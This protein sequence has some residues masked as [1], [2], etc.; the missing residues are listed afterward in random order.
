MKVDKVARHI[1]SNHEKAKECTVS[2]E[3]WRLKTNGVRALQFD[4]FFTSIPQAEELSRNLPERDRMLRGTE[5][6]DYDP[7]KHDL[8]PMRL[9][10]RKEPMWVVVDKNH[11]SNHG[12]VRILIGSITLPNG[13]V[14]D[15]WET[16]RPSQ[17]IVDFEIEGVVPMVFLHPVFIRLFEDVGEMKMK[18]TSPLS[19]ALASALSGRSSAAA[20]AA[21]ES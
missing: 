7:Q 17:W 6:F 2:G 8:L 9:R 3:R 12:S 20:G 18:A 19:A 10:N 15:M 21:G 16:I 5:R 14:R 11:N 1:G 13:S 4:G